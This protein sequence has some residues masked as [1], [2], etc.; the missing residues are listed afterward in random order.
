MTRPDRSLKLRA[1]VIALVVFAVLHML[2]LVAARS[3][4]ETPERIATVAPMLNVAAYL[5]YL[6]AG[7]IAGAFAKNAP[8]LHGV[9]VGFF[10]AIVAIVFFRAD[11]RDFFSVAVL[12]ANGVIFGGIGG[13]CSLLLT[14]DARKDV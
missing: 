2:L 6:V 7:F 8:V 14:R 1:I 9:T 11:Q 3:F 13:T 10:A 12:V 5:I 4:S